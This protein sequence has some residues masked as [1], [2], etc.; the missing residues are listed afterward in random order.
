MANNRV[1]FQHGM[2]MPKL[3]RHSGTE[4]QCADALKL[5]RW[6]VGPLARWPD[7]PLARWLSLPALQ[8]APITRSPGMAP[9]SSS[10]ATAVA[11]KPR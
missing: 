9:A 7:G 11:I 3:Q 5:A 6:P 1:Q 4:P 10:S 8:T 2:Q